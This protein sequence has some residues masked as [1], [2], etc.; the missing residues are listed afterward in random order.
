MS[1]K[2]LIVEDNEKNLCLLRDILTYHGY[3][4]AVARDGQEGVALARELMP[5]LVLMDIQMPCLDG[6]AALRTLKAD[7]ATSGLKIVAMTSFVMQGD[8][9]KFMTAGFD[10]FLAKPISTREIPE[11]VKRWLDMEEK[12]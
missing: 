8:R 9:D 11:L 6:M 10:D 3:D 12:A 7:A 4:V 1:H 5:E 2:I